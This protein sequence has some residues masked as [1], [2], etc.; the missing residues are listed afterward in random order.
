MRPQHRQSL[1]TSNPAIATLTG[2]AGESFSNGCRNNV[3]CKL[4]TNSNLAYKRQIQIQ[5]RQKPLSIIQHRLA[6]RNPICDTNGDA[7][8]VTTGAKR[9]PKHQELP[10][11]T[12]VRSSLL[13]ALLLLP[14]LPAQDVRMKDDTGSRTRRAMGWVTGFTATNTRTQLTQRHQA[15]PVIQLHQIRNAA[16][17][18]SAVTNARAHQQPKGYRARHHGSPVRIINVT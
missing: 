5:V 6:N 14:H 16:T 18:S 17:F 10:N 3:P 4:A 11:G 12:N 9:V 1:H 2:Q 15:R 13:L 8:R 7:L